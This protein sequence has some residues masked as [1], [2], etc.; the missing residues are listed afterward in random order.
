MY[1][2]LNVFLSQSIA[3]YRMTHRIFGCMIAILLVLSIPGY[4]FQKTPYQS[5]ND[6]P[7]PK[8]SGT[9]Y[10]SNPDGLIDPTELDSLNNLLAELNRRTGIETAVVIISDFT[11][12]D[13]DFTF[14]TALFRHWGIGKG[15]SN[16]GLLL[17][18]ATERRQYRFVTGYGLEGLLPDITL[19][20]I[21]DRILVPAFKEQAYGSGIINAVKVIS[22]YLQQ[23][24]NKK[25][26]DTLFNNQKITTS[27][28]STKTILFA[29][30]IL[31]AIV[32]GW[33]LNK[34]KASISKAK[35]KLSNLYADI[36]FWSAIVLLCC[37]FFLSTVGFFSGHFMDMLWSVFNF[38]P[39][40]ICLIIVLYLFFAHLNIL[41]SLRMSHKD[42]VNY[43]ES[44]G[45]FYRQSWWHT[46]LSPI[47][48]III[49]I[50]LVQITRLKKRIKAPLDNNG[51]PMRRCDRDAEE[52]NQ[53][54]SSGQLK[55][56]DTGSLIYD[57]WTTE[58]AEEIKLISNPGYH[59]ADFEVCP[60]CGFRTYTQPI[61]ITIERATYA[62]GGR[63][64]RVNLC[65]NCDHEH[66]IEFIMLDKLV[67]TNNSSSSGG[68]S[69]SSGSGSSSNSSS[70]SW[71]GGSTGGGGAGGRW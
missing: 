47:L 30:A 19:S 58:H 28:A 12:N 33:Q 40:V 36:S 24:A 37:V 67:R 45:K 56:E 27:G 13:D 55:E 41:S 46:L 21:G 69:S 44:F 57:I 39:L 26:L 14:S 8:D 5:V 43:F 31:S 34:I 48:L 59:Y 61:E 11:K 52:V 35:Q 3:V 49:F 62:H 65:R 20:T 50:Q 60:A 32:A 17:L 9:G 42:D 38:F 2:K 1:T 18:I 7:N 70:S 54:L 22:G 16:N 66:F 51:M 23:P 10:V 71:G 4:A 25:E 15:G 6:V 68:G 64:K 29:I 53:Y 63:A